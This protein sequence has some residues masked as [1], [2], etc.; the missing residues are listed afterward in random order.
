VVTVPPDAEVGRVAER[1]A[2]RG[3]GCVVV[4]GEGSRPIGV[5]TDRD[6]A[7]RVIGAGRDSGSTPASAV[8][9]HPVR[10]ADASLSFDRVVSEMREHGIRRMP[11]VDGTKLVGL[12]ALDDVVSELARD[13]A[14]LDEASHREIRHARRSERLRRVRGD[15]ERLV[16]TCTE[17]AEALGERTQSAL[18]RELDGIREKLRKWTR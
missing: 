5:I 2:E 12:V 14:A 13:L 15:L 17:E 4:V 8:M 10:T 7:I 3:V 9:S 18:A 1:M 16:A 11:I 6:L